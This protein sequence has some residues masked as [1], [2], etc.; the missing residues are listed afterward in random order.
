MYSLQSAHFLCLLLTC[1]Y[2]IRIHFCPQHWL[3]CHLVL[4]SF[5]FEVETIIK[6]D[7]RWNMEPSSTSVHP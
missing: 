6:Y 2:R 4:Q 7:V 1:V 3:L 5:E